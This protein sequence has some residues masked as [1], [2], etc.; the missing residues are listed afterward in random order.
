MSRP[1]H[2]SFRV[3]VYPRGPLT[4]HPANPSGRSC[5]LWS[6]GPR[7]LKV[8][9]RP[10]DRGLQV[11]TRVTDTKSRPVRTLATFRPQESSP[12]VPSWWTRVPRSWTRRR[13][14]PGR[15]VHVNGRPIYRSRWGKRSSCRRRT[16][17]SWT[18]ERG[19]SP[20]DLTAR[21]DVCPARDRRHPSDTTGLPS[22][23]WTFRSP[24]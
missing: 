5:H 19:R 13:R 16:W 12:R 1:H 21:R 22:E 10:R 4:P 24:G 9:G 17:W 18:Q 2:E 23:V 3:W 11:P 6:G 7:L 8:G 14:L 15:T 20:P